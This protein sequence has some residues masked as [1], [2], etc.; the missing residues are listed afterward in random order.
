M[1]ADTANAVLA[2]TGDDV[3]AIRKANV[4]VHDRTAHG[5]HQTDATRK[6]A[7]ARDAGRR[8]AREIAKTFRLV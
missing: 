5:R 8:G 6:A 2:S 4:A 7:S 1:W 3:T